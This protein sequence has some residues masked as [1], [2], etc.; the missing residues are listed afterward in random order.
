MRESMEIVC[1]AEAGDADMPQTEADAPE[2][3][4]QTSVVLSAA[5]ASIQKYAV[6]QLSL[7]SSNQQQVARLRR[8]KSSKRLQMRRMRACCRRL[9][10]HISLCG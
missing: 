6:Q 8:S 4:P 2:M 9:T 1:E 3:V 5:K 10:T 7:A